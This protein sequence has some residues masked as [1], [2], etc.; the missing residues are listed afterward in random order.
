MPEC[1]HSLTTFIHKVER[2]MESRYGLTLPDMHV[3]VLADSWREG[4]T[5]QQFMDWF[6]EKY[7]LTPIQ[8]VPEPF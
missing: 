2:K 6:A 3:P 4:W 5:V 7:D 8:E 1:T